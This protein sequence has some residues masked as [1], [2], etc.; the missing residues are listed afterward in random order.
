MAV[1][2]AGER[3]GVAA[4]GWRIPITL[5]LLMVI[6]L[7]GGCYEIPQE[8]IPASFGVIIPDAPDQADFE[9]GGKIF[10]TR[11]NSNHDYRFRDVSYSGG[12]RQ[13]TL[14]AMRIKDSV[15]AIQARYDDESK[16]QI[17]FYSIN[18]EHIRMTDVVVGTD[19][20]IFASLYGVEYQ[21]DELNKGFSGKPEK[22]LAMLRG[23]SSVDFEP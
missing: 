1:F 21:G 11:S 4:N 17:V 23:M 12:E 19:L 18:A 3:A 16:Y 13:G 15:Y 6:L 2:P 20:K 22:I 14:R 7:L 10:F 9:G 5:G 8:V